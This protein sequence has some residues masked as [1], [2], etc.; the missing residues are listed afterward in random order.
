MHLA[1]ALVIIIVGGMVAK[2]GFYAVFVFWIFLGV[3]QW[4]YLYPAIRFSR[5]RG[6]P[7]VVLGMWIAGGMTLALGLLQLGS[8]LVPTL[9]EK[10]TG[11]SANNVE[12]SGSDSRVVSTDSTHIVVREGLGTATSPGAS[13][14]E[15]YVVAPET[16]ID[17][18]GPAW[19]D[20]ARPADL[21]WLTPGRRVSISYVIRHRER[22]AVFVAIW[23][24]TPEP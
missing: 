3:L 7:G 2:E 12:Y 18:R 20:Q 10:V 15:T 5:S 8:A 24:E 14:T 9:V 13:G 1:V 21:T 16:K 17:F 19:R 23:V 22:V 6:W 11:N 4:I